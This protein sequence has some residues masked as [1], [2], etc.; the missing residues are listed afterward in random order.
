TERHPKNGSRRDSLPH[1]LLRGW[2]RP[3]SCPPLLRSRSR[4]LTP[5]IQ[6]QTGRSSRRTNPASTIPTQ[7][8]DE[9]FEPN[10][11]LVFLS[12]DMTHPGPDLGEVEHVDGRKHLLDVEP[13]LWAV[14]GR[15]RNHEM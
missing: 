15:F 6:E 13:V 4:S 12:G 2:R 9:V 14:E 7:P 11:P 3:V 5:S 1:S 8:I 10:H